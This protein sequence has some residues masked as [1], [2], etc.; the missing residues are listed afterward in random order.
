[1][2][3][4]VSFLKSKYDLKTTIDKINETQADYIHVDVMDGVFVS[5]KTSDISE[6]INA[7]KDNIKP[8]DI[9]IMAI[10]NIKYIKEY[11]SLKPK[12]ITFHIE[13]IKNIH[14]AIKLIKDNNVKVGIAINPETRLYSIIPYLE[15]IDLVLVMGVKPGFGGQGFIKE[16][17]N[18]INELKAIQPKYNFI[19]N[20]DGGVNDETIKYINSDM[21]VSGSYVCMNDDMTEAIKTLKL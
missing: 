4:S 19:I 17:I 2:K 11:L 20:V 8:L 9:H 7:F 21:V 12:Y 1:M 6:I 16:T 5:N 18:K 10:D 15:I 13:S 14:E 3:V